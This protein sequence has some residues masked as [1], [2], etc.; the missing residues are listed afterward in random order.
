[1][2]VEIHESSCHRHRLFVQ[3]LKIEHR[4]YVLLQR[5]LILPKVLAL[6]IQNLVK[7]KSPLFDRT[8]SS[9][10]SI[11]FGIG[12][13]SVMKIDSNKISIRFGTNRSRNIIE[14]I[15]GV[16]NRFVCSPT[17]WPWSL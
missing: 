7:E 10:D 3:L 13:I 17:Y 11:S 4:G 15:S 9:T 6:V 16:E 12:S 14:P 8:L 5:L 1:M 2:S